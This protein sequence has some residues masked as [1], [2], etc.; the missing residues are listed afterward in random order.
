[1]GCPSTVLSSDQERAIFGP[2]NHQ[3]AKA[4]VKI[5]QRVDGKAVTTPN[6]GPLER[7]GLMKEAFQNSVQVDT[8]GRHDGWGNAWIWCV[9]ESHP[10]GSLQS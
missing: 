2:P 1:M 8:Q 10:L 3:T 4:V 6:L 9:M 7:T 5:V